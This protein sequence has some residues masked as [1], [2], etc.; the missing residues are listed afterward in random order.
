LCFSFSLSLLFVGAAVGISGDDF[1]E[2]SDDD[3]PDVVNEAERARSRRRL[4]R[5]HSRSRLSGVHAT[6]GR[7]LSSSDLSDYGHEDHVSVLGSA[8]ITSIPFA[9]AGSGGG[10]S[11]LPSPFAGRGAQSSLFP[12]LGLTPTATTTTTTTTTGNGGRAAA[13][14]AYAMALASGTSPS[15]SPSHASQMSATAPFPVQHA[16]I[17]PSHT[18]VSSSTGG[19]GGNNNETTASWLQ[20]APVELP[21]EKDVLRRFTTAGGRGVISVARSTKAIQQRIKAHSAARHL[22][23]LREELASTTDRLDM[24]RKKLELEKDQLTYHENAIEQAEDELDYIR[25]EVQDDLA[26]L[27][28]EAVLNQRIEVAHA[29]VKAQKAVVEATQREFGQVD[30]ERYTILITTPPLHHIPSHHTNSTT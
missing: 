4:A 25:E 11:V 29:K 16:P 24:M 13:A 12:P 28:Q 15:P 26:R 21:S 14:A 22:E 2:H 19:G 9:V 6:T 20:R 30:K 10:Q 23:K 7:P 18:T 27:P 17:T 3:S 8:P 5:G 1:D